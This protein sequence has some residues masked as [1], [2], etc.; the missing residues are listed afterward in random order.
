MGDEFICRRCAKRFST[1]R[2]ADPHKEDGAGLCIQCYRNENVVSWGTRGGLFDG[3]TETVDFQWG[4]IT[5]PENSPTTSS[6]QSESSQPELSAQV[7]S[8]S[9]AED[10][11]TWQ[12][13]QSVEFIERTDESGEVHTYP[14]IEER[15]KEGER[16]RLSVE[17][18][19]RWGPIVGEAEVSSSIFDSD[20][21]RFPNEWVGQTASDPMPSL[22]D[23]RSPMAYFYRTFAAKGEGEPGTEAQLAYESVHEFD[24]EVYQA[25]FPTALHPKDMETELVPVTEDEKPW[26]RLQLPPEWV[27][28][29]ADNDGIPPIKREVDDPVNEDDDNLE[30]K[31]ERANEA[32]NDLFEFGVI[33]EKERELL[34]ARVVD[35]IAPNE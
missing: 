4:D 5:L 17:M 14:K 24:I 2:L 33:T 19:R 15:T 20:D 28:R 27:E 16:Y 30:Q 18:Y 9:P 22:E 21:D 3:E 34:S 25:N 26:R 6:S 1:E 32:L 12:G 23:A 8:T 7:S 35:I 29:F 13:D 31:Q 10:E 11:G